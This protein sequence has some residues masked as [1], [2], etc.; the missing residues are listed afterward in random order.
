MDKGHK[1]NLS[2]TLKCS[3]VISSKQSCL[4]EKSRKSGD[5]IKGSL[6]TF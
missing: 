3:Y 2:L 6:Y 5:S 4:H 1:T